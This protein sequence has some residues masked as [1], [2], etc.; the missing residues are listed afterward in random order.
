MRTRYVRGRVRALSALCTALLVGS[1]LAGCGGDGGSGSGDGK[2]TLNVGLFG[3]FGFEEAGLYAEYQQT[4]PGVRIVQH[5]TEKEEDYWRTVQTRLA[6]GGGID[7]IQGIEVGRIAD[8]VRNQADKWVDLN[9]LGLAGGNAEYLPW[10]SKAATTAD[11]KVLGVGT[12]IGPM[13]ICYRSDLFR[14]AGLPTDREELARRW[15]TWEGYVEL[16]RQFQANAPKKTHYLDSVTGLYNAIIGQQQESYYDAAGKPIYDTNPTVKHAWDLAA[17]AADGKLSAALQQFQ[18]D[19]NQ[20]FSADGFA[21]LSCPA[22][23]IGYIKTQAGDA[24]KGKWDVAAG[25]GGTGNWGGSYLAVP[26]GGKHHKEAAELVAWLTAPEQQAKMFRKQGNFPSKTGAIES[27]K[28]TL[29]PYFNNAPIGAI[30]SAA[31]ERMP[32]QVTGVRHN[33]IK[34]NITTALTSVEAQGVKP[35][36]AWKRARD[37]VKNALAS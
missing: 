31:A 20:A 35:D 28:A 9:S 4:H 34:D 6:G 11:G 18:S 37:A 23:M 5:D 30:F 32:V 29:D 14:A 3:T 19:W 17:Q 21:S 26:K 7:D 8:V 1:V 25:P 24:G 15:S 10:K 13:A 16:G 27:V 2:V 22:W 36:D 33:D 12:D